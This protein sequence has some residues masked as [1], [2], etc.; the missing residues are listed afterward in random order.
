L[1]FWQMAN[2]YSGKWTNGS[3]LGAAAW[4][5]IRRE[6][7]RVAY[8]QIWLYLYAVIFSFWSLYWCICW[9]INLGLQMDSWFVLVFV[10]V[11]LYP[12]LVC[13]YVN[14]N[15]LLRLLWFKP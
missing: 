2:G 7:S 11:P 10:N 5:I 15:L 9:W 13:I 12:G 8:M 4:P 1:H 14:M 3:I 6:S